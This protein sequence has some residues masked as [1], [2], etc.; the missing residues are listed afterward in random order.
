[1]KIL[2]IH[3]LDKGWCDKDSVMLH[4]AFQLLVDFMEQEKPDRI[5][6]WNGDSLHKKAWK[7]IRFLYRW[8]TETRPARRDPLDA[9][10]LKKPSMRWR[11]VTGSDCRQLVAY[12]KKK[13]PEYERALN[14]Q[15]R[16]E[17]EWEDED[18]KNLHRLVEIRGFLWT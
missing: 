10:G 6:D 13:Y 12:D 16:L 15:M 17:K 4:A 5:V 1:M 9:R 18:R 7:E 2:K 11:K 3:T 14:E 8:W